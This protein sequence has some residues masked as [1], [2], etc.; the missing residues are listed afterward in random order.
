M[1]TKTSEEDRVGWSSDCSGD[2]ETPNWN[3]L[4]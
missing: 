3:S 1:Q 2:T 4:G